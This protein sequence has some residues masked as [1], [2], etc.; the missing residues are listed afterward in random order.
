MHYWDDNNA[1]RVLVCKSVRDSISFE[2]VFRIKLNHREIQW[3]GVD[4]NHVAQDRVRWQALLNMI[5]D[6]RAP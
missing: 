5:I 4:W 6:I 3:D 1:C 2:K